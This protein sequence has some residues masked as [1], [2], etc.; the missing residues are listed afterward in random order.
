METVKNVNRLVDFENMLTMKENNQEMDLTNAKKFI[1]SFI[2]TNF[3]FHSQ[4]QNYIR[5]TNSTNTG[6]TQ[7]Q[8]ADDISDHQNITIGEG[9]PHPNTV[10]SDL[11]YFKVNKT[12]FHCCFD[13]LSK[14]LFSKLKISYIEQETK[15]RYLRAILDNPIL[16]VES[17]DNIELEKKNI[18]LKSRLK[19]QKESVD[20]TCKKLEQVISKIC[21]DYDSMIQQAIEANNMLKEIEKMEE[22]IKE[23]QDNQQ[24]MEQ[25]LPLKDSLSLLSSQTK[26]SSKLKKDIEQFQLVYERKKKQLKEAI[27]DVKKQENEKRCCEAFAK[28]VLNTRRTFAMSNKYK[29]EHSGIWHQSLLNLQTALLQIKK[30]QYDESQEHVSFTLETR[31]GCLPIHLYFKNGQFYDAHTDPSINIQE[32]VFQAKKYNDPLFF[33]NTILLKI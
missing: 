17:K 18:E 16:V 24:N 27:D 30:F 20:E 13:T 4:K 9:V 26:K 7:Q 10:E 28:E 1:S 14:E 31:K 29:K 25:N 19:S 33:I 11:K 21:N 23:L 2:S 32:I 5:K 6:S 8:D 3:F 12:F 15:E 22:E